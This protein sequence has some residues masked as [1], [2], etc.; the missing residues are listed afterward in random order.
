MPGVATTLAWVMPVKVD[1]LGAHL[2]AYV[3]LL[4]TLNTLRL[5]HR[6]GGPAAPITRLPAELIL[7]IEEILTLEERK[8]KLQEWTQDFKC[9]ESKCKIADHF[10]FDEFDREMIWEIIMKG[11]FPSDSEDEDAWDQCFDDFIAEETDWID[12]AF[13]T[14]EDRHYSWERRADSSTSVF[15]T[16]RELMTHHF[17]LDV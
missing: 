17:G 6:Y 16:N 4:P 3:K 14:H 8:K 5:S 15:S 9:F 10:D 12:D 11:D 7:H 13:D 1:A 2:E